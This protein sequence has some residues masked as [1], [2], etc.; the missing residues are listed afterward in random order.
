[1][2]TAT[3][4]KYAQKL[5]S[6]RLYKDYKQDTISKIL[7]FNSQQQ[8]SKLENGQ[9]SFSDDIIRKICKEFEIS[10][11]DFIGSGQ[12]LKFSK[13]L[14]SNS[15]NNLN[16]EVLLIHELLRAK[17]DIIKSLKEQINIIKEKNS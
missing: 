17:D 6:L 10:F 2:V 11:D 8:Y 12:S 14:N 15:N 16:D 13:D 4:I 7:G 1:M 5:R 3:D 9:M